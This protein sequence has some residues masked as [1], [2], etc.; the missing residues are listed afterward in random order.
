MRRVTVDVK[1]KQL[2][3]LGWVEREDGCR[4]DEACGE[5]VWVEGS[6]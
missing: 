5:K 4:D 2:Q 6:Y 1:E 3:V